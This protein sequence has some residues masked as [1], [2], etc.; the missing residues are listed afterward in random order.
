[1][2]INLSANRLTDRVSFVPI[3]GRA[4]RWAIIGCEEAEEQGRRGSVPILLV[5]QLP[6]LFGLRIGTR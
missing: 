4:V 3:C 6:R 1:M 2:M 5:A